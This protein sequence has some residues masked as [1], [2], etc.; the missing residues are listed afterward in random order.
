VRV[1]VLGAGFGGLEL[2]ARLSE[3]LGDDADVTLIDRTD[4]FMFGFSKLDVMFG[5]R[6]PSAVRLPYRNIAKPG[7]R[8]VQETITSI[9]PA[10]K[11][12]TSDGDTYDADVLV[13][14]LGAD[15]DATATPGLEETGNEYYT[16]EGAEQLR[17]VLPSFEGGDAV[18]GVCGGTF[19]CPPAPS[20]AGLLLDGYLRD[21]GLRDA[22]T[23]S[24][25]I[26][27]GAPVPPS[28]E[29]SEALLRAFD[30]RGIA[31]VPTRTVAALENGEA[32]LDDGRRLPCDLFL[33]IPVH[34]VP[35]VVEASGLAENGWIPVDPHTLET[36]F[37]DVYAVGDVT[38]V[39]TPKAGVFAEGAA[40]TVADRLI[41]IARG[42]DPSAAYDGKGSCYI[43][44]G[45]DQVARV[46][47]DFF[48]TPGRPSGT[49]VPPSTATAQEKAEFKRT[50][51]ARWFGAS[52]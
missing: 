38:S 6:T 27:F 2:S 22:A 7:V 5:T 48:S 25:V 40:R 15:L 42:D 36:R 14:A 49:W 31:F 9:D 20:E 37:P 45:N 11:R 34:R 13:V 23:I 18:V 21:R 30:E 16:E 52:A 35:E 24:V 3:A 43:E 1:V 19:K 33:G 39:G 4:A 41:A 26:P 12:V 28:P 51:N 44:F 32:V 8:F 46:D 47:V 29:T 10:A 17:D 50:R